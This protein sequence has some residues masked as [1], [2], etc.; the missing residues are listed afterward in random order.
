MRVSSRTQPRRP[1][2]GMRVS[3]F[4]DSNPHMPVRDLLLCRYLVAR[5]FQPE[6]LSP[7]RRTASLALPTHPR[8]S[9]PQTR[10]PYGSR[11]SSRGC[12]RSSSAPAIERADISVLAAGTNARPLSRSGGRKIPWRMLV[13]GDEKHISLTELPASIEPSATLRCPSPSGSP[14]T[15]PS[16]CPAAEAVAG[17]RL[18]PSRHMQL[19]AAI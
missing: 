3:G 8:A 16:A 15:F 2:S 10:V 13:R 18:L 9:N 12:F 17:F 11:R 19:L 1:S 7:R 5:L 4:D 6:Q 14:C